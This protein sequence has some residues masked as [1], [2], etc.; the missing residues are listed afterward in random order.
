MINTS[1]APHLEI[2]LRFHQITRSV[3]PTFPPPKQQAHGHSIRQI[4]TQGSAMPYIVVCDGLNRLN[5]TRPG[6]FETA[7]NDRRQWCETHVPGAHEIEPIGPNPEQLTGRRF[8]F[9]DQKAA[10]M[11][12]LSFPTDLWP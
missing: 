8:R 5:L 6:E 11:F 4:T 1:R 10:A 3:H 7:L 2:T 9:S 12:K